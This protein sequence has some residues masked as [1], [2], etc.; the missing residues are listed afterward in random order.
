MTKKSIFVVL[1]VALIVAICILFWLRRFVAVEHFADSTPKEEVE[2][3]VIHHRPNKER[4][5][6]VN[7]QQQVLGKPIHIFD[8]IMGKDL[9]NIRDLRSFDERLQSNYRIETS[10]VENVHGCYL[11]HFMLIKQLLS[12]NKTNPE[13]YTV[14]FEDDIRILDDHLDNSLRHILHI[15][16][17]D[18]DILFL[19]NLTD[20]HG[21]K[22]AENIFEKDP[23]N[24]INGTHAYVIK[25]QHLAK[26]YEVLLNLNEAID[27]KYSNAIY[28]NELNALLIYP[29]LVEQNGSPSIIKV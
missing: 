14:V 21:E 20:N 17:K 19:G 2:Y 27:W 9:A 1:F 15:I 23:K 8:A 4:E 25:N 26:I 28:A 13:G 16:Q 12:D 10:N 6:N 18:F 7:H 5:N 22:Y 11:S 3:Y 24:Y 29:V